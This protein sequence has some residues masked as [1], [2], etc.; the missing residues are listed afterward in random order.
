[1]FLPNGLAR[2]AVRFRPSG[3]VGTFVALAMAALIVSACG[4]LLETGLRA[5]VPPDRYAAAPVVAAA[6]QKAHYGHGDSAASEPV[7]DRARLDTSLVDRAASAPGV[8]TAVADV[9]F[10]ALPAGAKGPRGPLTAHNWASTTF[11][12]ERLTAGRAPGPGEVVLTRGTVGD[13]V[14]LATPDGT[15]T[16]RVS[17][18]TGGDR[19][20][21]GEPGTGHP[22]VWFADAEAV[23][24][25][26]HPG[27]VDA[28]AVLPEPGVTTAALA[29]QVA[30]ALGDRAEVHTGDDRG[31]VEDPALG[32]AKENLTGIG[33]SFGG[34]AAVVA[35]FTAAGTVALAV[36]QRAR[37]F[38]LLR[39]VG[40]TPRQIRRT[41]ATETLLVA[42][43]AGVAGCLPGI[44]LAAWWFGQ[45][46]DKGAVP[47]AVDLSVSWIPLVSAAGA[48]LVG[49]LGAGYMA[50]HRSS[51]VKPG[52]AL[53]EAS[54]ERLRFGWI[55]TPLGLA[56]AAGGFV[57]AGLSASLTGEDAANAALGIVMLF[58]L[59]VALL[60]PLVAR[61]CAALFGLPLRGAGASASLA[62]ANSRT[63]ARRL[64]SAITPIVLAMAFSS[65]LV[66]MH[67]SEDRVTARQQREG[68]LAD[69]IV[70]GDP[71]LAPDA[72]RKAGRAPEVTAAVGLLRTSVL[73]PAS[74]GVIVPASAQGVTG[75]A[76]A[77]AAVQDLDVERGRLS[78]ASGEVAVDAALA[79]NAGLAVGDR[80]PLRLP[81]G[82]RTEPRITATYGRGLGL[83]QV[84]MNRA[85]LATHVTTAFDTELWTKGG[86]AA[87]LR[88]LGTVLDR[89]DHTTAQS[90]DRELNAWANTVMAA[91]L[92]GFAAVAAVNTLVMTVLDRRRELGTL[93]LIGSTRRQVLRMVRWEALLVALA[94]IVLGTAI[95]LA[96][97][98]PMMKGL[99][100]EGPY[101]PPLVYGAFA[102]TI[103]VLGL[104]AA[105]L[106]ARAALRSDTLDE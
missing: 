77:L 82:T 30:R 27:R 71:G 34:I 32:M 4:I 74:G 52:Q 33:G 13:R 17:G 73:V 58:M 50:A 57:C 21:D 46:K 48:V 91:V 8:R 72:V 15:R 9:T 39:A 69:H 2:A 87:G 95:A 93:R 97:L 38:A 49:A 60:G 29:S 70:T 63:N 45:L 67:T 55:R 40:A 90:V 75:S 43:L 20:A 6:D 18:T 12:G 68:I 96:T 65:V 89:A 54:V 66:F 78:L 36:G 24:R 94:G 81:D 37:E 59:A 47:E 44:A 85:D 16:Y 80:L 61:L 86:T 76:R 42:P 1:M 64:A 83:S 101:I 35:V 53:S 98:V 103:V 10:W 106:P 11:T 23:Q 105:T 7:P 28:I 22:T 104:T 100:G 62:A 3:F 88:S 14:T 79:D 56:A 31:T 102:G 84:T 25:S 99:T 5:A 92:G 41:I 19:A 51:R 26:G